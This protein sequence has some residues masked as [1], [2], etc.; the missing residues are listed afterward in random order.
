MVDG[1]PGGGGGQRFSSDTPTVAQ[2]ASTETMTARAAMTRA[3]VCL[4][5]R[6]SSRRFCSLASRSA[7]S[8]ISRS[9]S[10]LWIRCRS[11]QFLSMC[12]FGVSAGI[13]RVNSGHS[14]GSFMVRTPS[15]G[16]IAGVFP[17]PS[18]PMAQIGV[19]SRFA[20]E[21]LLAGGI[22]F[23]RCSLPGPTKFWVSR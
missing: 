14:R 22:P 23:A 16:Q 7:R 2:T 21:L 15:A 1:G 20:R 3:M 9:C 17:N 12:S 6:Q 5:S 10:S 19:V 8:L 11:R 13:H 18:A 4:T